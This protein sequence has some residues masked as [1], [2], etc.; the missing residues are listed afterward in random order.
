MEE[1]RTTRGHYRHGC[2]RTPGRSTSKALPQ[3][4]RASTT[5]IATLSRWVMAAAIT[6]TPISNT[7]SERNALAPRPERGGGSAHEQD[8]V[9][10]ATRSCGVR[11][12]CSHL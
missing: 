1:L 5:N 9:S 7:E 3:P 8:D 11:R 12:N 4:Y 6:S 2:G 10:N